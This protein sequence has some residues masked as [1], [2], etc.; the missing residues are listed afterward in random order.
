M[1]SSFGT[2]FKP[3][4]GSSEHRDSGHKNDSSGKL[5]GGKIAREKSAAPNEKPHHCPQRNGQSHFAPAGLDYAAGW[6]LGG[7]SSAAFTISSSIFLN[8]ARP[9]E[10]MMMVSRRPPTSSVMRRKRPRGF[11]LSV[12]TKFFRSICTSPFLSVSSTTG[13]LGWAYFGAP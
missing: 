12:N 6:S 9:V 3:C 5:P 1:S 4:G 2:V 8:S 10:G 11:S 7:I 13:G